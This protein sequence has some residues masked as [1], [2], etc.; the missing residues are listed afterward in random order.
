MFKPRGSMTRIGPEFSSVTEFS[1]VTI[2]SV[3]EAIIFVPI[4]FALLV[5]GILSV[6][7]SAQ[8]QLTRFDGINPFDEMGYSVSMI[9]DVD[10]DGFAD[11]LAGA[12]EASPGGRLDA[13]EAL[14][15]SGR[16]NSLIHRIEGEAANDFLGW[17]VSG[18]G[19]VND[20]GVPDFV[21]GAPFASPGGLSWAGVAY[22]F[23][24]V[25]GSEIHRVEGTSEFD[26][27][28]YSVSAAGDFNQDG[29]C[30]VIIGVPFSSPMGINEAGQAVVVSGFDA[31]PL[32]VIRG[33]FAG[34][35]LGFSVAGAG[36]INGDSFPDVIVGAPQFDG[37]AGSRTG[38]AYV[39]L[40]PLGMVSYRLVGEEAGIEFGTSVAG[41]GNVDGLGFDEV[42][43][44]SPRATENGIFRSGNYIVFDGVS[45]AEVYR[46]GG[47][48]VED[49][50]GISVAG[51][52]DVNGDGFDDVLGGAYLADPL[53]L[54]NAG[55]AWLS[56]GPA[57]A[58]RRVIEGTS[59]GIRFGY[60]VAG[61]ADVNGD[62]YSDIV[63]GADELSPG[64]RRGA[65]AVYA[66]TGESLSVLARQG[67]VDLSLG[68]AQRVLTVN[69]S[70]GSGPN[71]EVVLGLNDP[72]DVFMDRPASL[73]SGTARYV[74]YFSIGTT[75]DT[76]VRRQEA[77]GFVFGC[78]AFPTPLNP[79]SNG[80]RKTL[81]NLGHAQILGSFDFVPAPAPATV[82]LVTRGG[83]REVTVSLQGFIENTSSPSGLLAIT[84]GIT[85]R[86]ENL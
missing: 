41:V 40:G 76:T 10:G 45:G 15:F 26:R 8:T 38:A 13:G 63:M 62:G 81:S 53:G 78:M 6:E 49:R 24:G 70:T 35:K 34:D 29:Y 5:A 66:Y 60:S 32:A 54:L 20:D 61:A 59:G 27:L 47:R 74:V 28:G 22:I 1:R 64:G 3:R 65:G 17:S 37:L 36:N 4:V 42:A 72:I 33:E 75:D 9:G 30:D 51:A 85:L 39:A 77:G 67:N 69:G 19:D 80:I 11:V 68:V 79:E 73:G 7:S 31:T 52:G 16:D 58:D 57:G 86:V 12:D 25:D 2:G 71:H 82:V 21:V 44:G 56:F 50:L 43:V 46:V 83:N 48:G 84:N 23:S 14:V 55:E 18:A